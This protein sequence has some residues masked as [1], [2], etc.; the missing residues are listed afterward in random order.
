[1]E[2][3]WSYWLVAWVFM[4]LTFLIATGAILMGAFALDKENKYP[5][6]GAH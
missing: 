2:F 5:D 3:Y 4:G 1:M 6:E